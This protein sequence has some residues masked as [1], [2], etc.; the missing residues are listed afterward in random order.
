[1][2]QSGPIVSSAWLAEA[3]RSL[4]KRLVIAEASWTPS[5]EATEYD[6]GHIPGAIHV[7]TDGFENGSP[8][9]HLRPVPEL[10]AVIGALGIAPDS[11]VVVYGHQTIAAARV[12]WIL[13]YAGV[14]RVLYLDGGVE[15]WRRAGFALESKPN[16]L[17]RVH[18]AAPPRA[19]VLA[20]TEY[21]RAHREQAILADVR[22]GREYLGEV[23]G[24][25]YLE[26]KGRIPGARALGDGS[27]SAHVYQNPDGT[28]R[29][30]GEIRDRWQAAGILSGN[31]EIVFY[32]GSGW[33]SSLAFLYARAMGLRRIRN[34]S[35][36]WSGWSTIYEQV[37]GEWRQR[38]SAN[39]VANG[40]R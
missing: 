34:Y 20:T 21:V 27:D 1:M 13:E 28:L 18:F 36:G 23:S 5:G 2:L 31:R 22:S 37:N 14:R 29:R 32:C 38:P 8:R 25:S 24:Y 40:E 17:P 11:T 16:A 15:A 19:G 39:P 33:R 9:W 10:H 30:V 6:A 12:W 3:K 26:A 35:D 4:G 7:N